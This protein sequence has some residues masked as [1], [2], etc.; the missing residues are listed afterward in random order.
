MKDGNVNP[1]ERAR[2]VLS[3]LQSEVLAELQ[4]RGE[5]GVA[6]LYRRTLKTVKNR[7]IMDD[8]YEPSE[9]LSLAR[10]LTML[11]RDLEVLCTD[12]EGEESC[13]EVCE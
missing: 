1:N 10:V 11:E 9:N 7:L 13:E 6:D 8:D 4:V 3:E 5:N 12:G 2:C